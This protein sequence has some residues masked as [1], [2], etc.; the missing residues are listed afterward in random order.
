[1]SDK[2]SLFGFRNLTSDSGFHVAFLVLLFIAAGAIAC[3]VL[4]A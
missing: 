4:P 1:M 3:Y 2:P